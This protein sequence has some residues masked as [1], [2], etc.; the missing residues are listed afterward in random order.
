MLDWLGCRVERRRNGSHKREGPFFVRIHFS[1]VEVDQRRTLDCLFAPAFAA[2]RMSNNRRVLLQNG[3]EPG[4][5]ARKVISGFGQTDFKVANQ[6]V[7][8][9][10]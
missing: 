2:G 9:P 7:R 10:R 1:N 3:S 5:G 8:G 4:R 6:R